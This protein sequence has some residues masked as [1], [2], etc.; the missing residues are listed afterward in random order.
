LAAQVLP[1]PTVGE[2]LGAVDGEALA[3]ALEQALF[4]AKVCA[5]AQGF[6]VIRAAS[7]EH[8]WCVIVMEV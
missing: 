7:E 4:A 8:G 5:Y 6:G 3:E 1:T 2:P